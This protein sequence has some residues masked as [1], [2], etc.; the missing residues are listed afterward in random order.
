VFVAHDHTGVALQGKGFFVA[1][2]LNLLPM[3]VSPTSWLSTSAWPLVKRQK[4]EFLSFHAGLQRT[5]P[6]PELKQQCDGKTEQ[7]DGRE[8][9]RPSFKTE[10]DANQ[11]QGSG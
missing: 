5:V 7:C 8:H 6:P 1:S 3:A 11:Y 9:K 10:A 4:G 2:M